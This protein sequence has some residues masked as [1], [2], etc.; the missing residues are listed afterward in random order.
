[1]QNPVAPTSEQTA[2]PLS[3]MLF[4]FVDRLVYLGWKHPHLPY[5]QLPDLCDYDRGAYLKDLGLQHILV[6]QGKRRIHLGLRIIK[7]FCLFYP[8]LPLSRPK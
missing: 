4:L 8:T 7:L 2:S 1:M 6:A 5:D 3:F